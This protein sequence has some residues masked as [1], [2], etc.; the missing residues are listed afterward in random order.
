MD[1]HEARRRRRLDQTPNIGNLNYDVDL[2][3]PENCLHSEGIESM[4]K[5]KGFAEYTDGKFDVAA[6]YGETIQ[7]SGMHQW[8]RYV[9]GRNYFGNELQEGTD[10]EIVKD[11]REEARATTGALVTRCSRC[12]SSPERQTGLPLR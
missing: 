8:T 11:E 9:Q 7:N 10:Y 1:R 6:T 4:P 12:S 5:E 2:N 3:D